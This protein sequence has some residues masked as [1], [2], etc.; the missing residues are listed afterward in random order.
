MKRNNP[1]R[2]EF[3]I[4]ITDHI[5]K[6][7]M[8]YVRDSGAD[9]TAAIQEIVRAGAL[10]HKSDMIEKKNSSLSSQIEYL[11]DEIKHFT[12]EIMRLEK[13]QNEYETD[14]EYINN[15]LNKLNAENKE[16]EAL[17]KQQSTALR[18]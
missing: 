2:I 4:N 17:L 18:K 8:K 13:L 7:A 10:R 12:T 5:F 9:K 11:R 14:A 1:D 16:H 15:R 3:T 6:Q